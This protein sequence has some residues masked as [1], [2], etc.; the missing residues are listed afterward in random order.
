ML[1]VL[2]RG[3]Q[4][5]EIR[6]S[7]LLVI[8]FQLPAMT[9]DQFFGDNLVQNL[10]IFLKIPPDMIR[11]THI[12]REGARRRKRST[13]LKVEVEIR[14]PPVQQMSNST[15]SMWYKLSQLYLQTLTD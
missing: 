12:I 2:V 7:P 10:A 6:T 15:D 1:K 8:A 4:P 9:E 11:I 3:S 13:G 5:V 14:K